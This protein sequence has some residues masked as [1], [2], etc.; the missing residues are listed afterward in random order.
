VCYYCAENNGIMHCIYTVCSFV[1]VCNSV[2]NACIL[3]CKHWPSR[4][5]ACTTETLF[6]WWSQWS[7]NLHVLSTADRLHVS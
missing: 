3:Q 4:G 5:C 2:S 7:K 6:W 1:V